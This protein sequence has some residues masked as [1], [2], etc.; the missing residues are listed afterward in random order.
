[1]IL[2]ALGVGLVLIAW[3]APAILIRSIARCF[4]SR[5]PR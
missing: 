1:M 4:R 3:H 2:L 5:P